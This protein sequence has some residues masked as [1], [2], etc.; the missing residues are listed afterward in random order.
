MILEEDMKIRKI[1]LPVTIAFA[2]IIGGFALSFVEAVSSATISGV[3]EIGQTLTLNTSLEYTD[4]HWYRYN[5]T[6][7]EVFVAHAS[8]TYVVTPADLGGYILVY[9]ILPEGSSPAYVQSNVFGPIVTTLHGNPVVGE[10]ITV[11]AS[12]PDFEYHLYKA[13]AGTAAWALVQSTASNTY[14]LQSS[15]EGYE[16]L[17]NVIRKADNLFLTQTNKIGPVAPASSSE[18]SSSESSSSEP[19]SS[20]ES[21]SEPSTPE[22]PATRFEGTLVVG[23]T[24]TIVTDLQYERIDWFH[25][26]DGNFPAIQ[27]ASGSSY[28]LQPEDVGHIIYA[29]IWLADEAFGAQLFTTEP[30]LAASGSEESSSEISSSEDPSS[31]D[32]GSGD[33]TTPGDKNIIWILISLFV[34][35]LLCIVAYNKRLKYCNLN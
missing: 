14:V 12:S 29:N 11:E 25:Y 13:P 15:D 17:V 33:S 32:T 7:G 4:L 31:V 26:D 2:L 3:P 28:T 27:G 10:T 30:V 22:L 24:L 19:S 9:V 5:P 8:N 6:D 23:N 18:E 34:V 20:E 16:F 35:S 21:S 1:V